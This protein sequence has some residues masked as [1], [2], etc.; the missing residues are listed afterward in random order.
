[1]TSVK[2][3]LR[4]SES[5]ERQIEYLLGRFETQSMEREDLATQHAELYE[6]E[7][8][9]RSI[10]QAEAEEKSQHLARE[11]DQRAR[12][13]EQRLASETAGK[14]K[15]ETDRD[16]ALQQLSIIQQRFGIVDRSGMTLGYGTTG[17]ATESKRQRSNSTSSSVSSNLEK[18][19]K[20]IQEGGDVRQSLLAYPGP[21]RPDD[22]NSLTSDGDDKVG[23]E[24]CCCVV[25]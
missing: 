23:S 10:R 2:Q 1:M 17:G 9:L 7:H 14:V 15:A 16:A 6:L 3:E 20:L 11:A 12:D 25:T 18:R 8:E 24:G 22:V 4:A 19:F 5:R 13:A 21:L